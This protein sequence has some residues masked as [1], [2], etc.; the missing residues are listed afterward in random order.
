MKKIAHQLKHRMQILKGTE[1]P[2]GIGI[3]IEYT[4]LFRLW[5]SIKNRKEQGIHGLQPVRL[6]NTGD[7]DTH[8]VLL[9]YSSIYNR[10]S[11]AYGDGFN[12]AYNADTSKGAGKEFD[13]AFSTDFNSIADFNPIKTDMFVYMEGNSPDAGRM[14]RIN[15]I[16]RDDTYKEWVKLVLTEVEEKGTGA[17]A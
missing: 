4:R 12:F 13:T 10:R 1:V 3:R 14:F 16:L 15:R 5:G 17:N 8:E 7:V 6:E 11:Q 9:R 2:Y